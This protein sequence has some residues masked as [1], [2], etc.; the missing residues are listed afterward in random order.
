MVPEVPSLVPTPQELSLG[1]LLNL[2]AQAVLVNS[3]MPLG[4]PPAIML[5]TS[6][7]APGVNYFGYRL[8]AL[9][10]GNQLAFLKGGTVVGTFTPADLIAALG[11]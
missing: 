4:A 9:D 3:S 6:G 10:T 11:P 7:A 1:R 8:S 5:S 2:V